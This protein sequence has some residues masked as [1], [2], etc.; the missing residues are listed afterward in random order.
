MLGLGLL[1]VA[2]D[3]LVVSAARLARAWGLS[4]VLIGA[5]VL[6]V[7][8]SLPEMLVSGLAAAAPNGLDLA[9]GNVIG[10]NIANLAMVLGLAALLSPMAGQLR[11]I[12]REGVMMLAAMVGFSVLAADGD[13]TR[14]DGLLLVLALVVALSLLVRWA[15]IDEADSDVVGSEVDEMLGEYPPSVRFELAIGFVSLLATLAGAR[16]LLTGAEGAGRE[17]GISEA[18]IGLTVV[19]VG[20][21]LPE[22][23]TALAAARRG[24]SDLVL[25]NVLGSNLFNALAVGGVSGLVGGGALTA[26]FGIPLLLM[27]GVSVLAGVMAATADELKRWEGAVLLASYVLLL[28]FG[29]PVS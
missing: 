13:L 11:I 7:G 12:R 24:E 26:D 27:L 28:A 6:G 25:G 22:L 9:M 4:S 17:L 18:V 2:A 8:T 15:R 19:A 29:L 21:S 16:L 1:T 3:R 20:T 14:F 10:S 5:V 23:A